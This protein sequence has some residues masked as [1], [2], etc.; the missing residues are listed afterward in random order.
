MQ[1]GVVLSFN[2]LA[3]DIISRTR[4]STA[5]TAGYTSAMQQ[6]IPTVICPIL[7][8]LFDA[9][10]YRMAVVSFASA[11]WII[12]YALIGYTTVNALGVMIV[13][14]LAFALTALP[15]LAS[16]PLMAPSQ[17]ELGLVFGVWK[18]FIHCG[19]VTVDMI[20]GRLQDITP[21]HTYERVIAFFLAW[22]ALELLLGLFYG[23]LD[24]RSVQHF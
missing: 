1:M 4:G 11:I 16:V 20:A 12:V 9:Y 23:V 24:R 8:A 10:G 17:L 15:F 7:G 18:S 22:K 19:R 6:I 13:S 14:S 2:E 5:R 3:P 21:G